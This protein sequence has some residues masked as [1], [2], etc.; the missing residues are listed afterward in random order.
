MKT[1]RECKWYERLKGRRGYCRNPKANYYGL[2]VY[3]GGK[4]ADF[5]F[6]KV[7]GKGGEQNESMGKNQRP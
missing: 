6:E 1:H 5:C 4:G 7:V 2:M 3:G